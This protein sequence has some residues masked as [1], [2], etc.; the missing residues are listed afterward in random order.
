MNKY[1]IAVIAGDGIG[2]EVIS[3]GKRILNRAAEMDGGFTFSYTDFPWGCEYYLRN[4][5]MMAE[6]ALSQLK[7]FDAIYLGAVGYPGVPDHISLRDL[8]LTIRQGF[9][10]YV[11]LRPVKLLRG[12]PCPLLKAKPEDIQM[13][14][15]RENSEG[16]YSGS[17]AWLYKNT[18]RETVIQNSVFSREGCERIIRYAFNIAEREGK[19]VTNVSKANALNYSMVFWDQVFEEISE[20]FPNVTTHHYLADAASMLMVKDPSRFEI[21]VT[22]NLF[23][24]ILTDLGAA[25]AGGMGL[26]AGANLNPE[27]KYPSMFEP[28]HGSAPDIAGKNTAN[29]MASI[30]AAAM[31]LEHFG[32]KEWSDRIITA[33]EKTLIEKNTLTPDL[34][35]TGTTIQLTDAIMRNLEE[36][37]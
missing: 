19:S 25:I 23:G 35:G 7:S 27:R 17:G 5:R 37:K 36:V 6:D 15:V 21:V 12:A 26:A 10:Q 11:N 33:M 16:E 8:L 4:G 32:M 3:Q 24:D 9:E 13:L 28:I 31:M 14:F 34:G 2:P 30:W 20:E 29:P 18:P 22:T 1:E